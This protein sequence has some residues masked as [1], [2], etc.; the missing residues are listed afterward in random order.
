[1]KA[2]LTRMLGQR[3]KRRNQR[4]VGAMD[5]QLKTE[6]TKH[7]ATMPAIIAGPTPLVMWP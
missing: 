6:L 2:T 5:G 1:M 4:N 7:R 3:W